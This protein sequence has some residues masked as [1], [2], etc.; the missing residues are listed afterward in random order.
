MVHVPSL[1]L[2]SRFPLVRYFSITTKENN[3]SALLIP[4]VQFDLRSCDGY[5]VMWD[6][7][8]LSEWWRLNSVPTVQPGTT[9]DLFVQPLHILGVFWFVFKTDVFTQ[10]LPKRSS[11][12]VARSD[13]WPPTTSEYFLGCLWIY[14]LSI[15]INA[16]VYPDQWQ[17]VCL[18]L[19]YQQSCMGQAPRLSCTLYISKAAVHPI[20]FSK[21][22]Y[23]L[24]FCRC[25]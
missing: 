20:L 24:G 7:N 25:I 17:P 3:T 9:T 16:M 11:V 10:S 5:A 13:Y 22:S 4:Q 23:F 8:L 12:S 21:E 14:R 19:H 1:S 6:A 15:K 2:H 18:F